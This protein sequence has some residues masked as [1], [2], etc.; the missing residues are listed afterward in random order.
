MSKPILGGIY[1]NETSNLQRKIRCLHIITRSDW[2]GGQKVLYSLVRGLKEYYNDE[3][4]VEVACGKENGMLI[5]ELES[6]EIKVHIV[7]DLVRELSPVK[8]LRAYCQLKRIINQGHFD[9]VHVHSSKAGILGRVAAKRSGVKNIIYTVH[10]WWPIEQYGGAKQN[11]FIAVERF[12][13]RYCDNIVF[14]C[15]KDREKAKIWKIGNEK[16][17]TVIPNAIIP[18]NFSSKGLLRKELGISEN[19]RIIGNV[20]RLDSPK[21]P[22]RFLSI[23]KE[24]ISKVNDVV[25][26]WIGGSIVEDFYGQ[27][28]EKFLRNKQE[29]EGKVFFLPFRKDANEL[30]ADF[31]A[32]L[33]TSDSEGMPLAVLEA[34]NFNIPVISTDVGC[35]SE[36]VDNVAKTDEELVEKIIETL[37]HQKP[38]MYEK[39]F[40]YDDFIAKYVKLY[41]GANEW[42]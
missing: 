42:K 11:L 28:V 34:L 6:I 13:A 25:F 3:I 2:A 19:I 16:Q 4:D 7:P 37:S 21:N 24:V 5:P 31:D 12:A 1:M 27:K 30:M 20:A 29:L 38:Y 33:L 18:L 17:H 36:I 35:I 8:D 41:K 22:L 32:F 23:A 40:E 15:Q 39:R 26:V 14:L 9:I 10:G